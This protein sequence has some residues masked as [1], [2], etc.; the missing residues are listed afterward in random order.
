L[1]TAIY[2]FSG[3]GNSL[4]VA[5]ELQKRLPD[6][7]LIPMVSLL[8]QKVITINAETMGIVFPIHLSTAP[9]PVRLFTEKLDIKS[10]NFIFAIATRTGYKHRAFIEIDNLL[11]KKGRKL[12]AY[13]TLNFIDNN[14]RFESYKVPTPEL[15]AQ[16]ES[17]NLSKLD[18]IQQ[19]ILNRE[20]RRDKDTDFIYQNGALI[21]LLM[22]LFAFMAK[23]PGSNDDFYADSNCSGCGICEEVC[24]AHKIK[25]IADQ[26]VWE[27]SIK[28]YSCRACLNYCP[29]QSV[30]IK[31]TR[32]VKS[33]TDQ[34]GRYPH[35]FAT[36]ND[37]V[38][39]K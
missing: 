1:S 39:Q 26:P 33:Y 29:L 21:E 31:S 14:P 36:I 13:F 28:C 8:D 11:K 30:Q 24:L 22:P 18:A 6:S 23:H 37:I 12:D 27:E 10:A 7:T 4:F 20:S 15:I 25:M 32:L 35:P 9:L 38:G 3:T 5:R 17:E 34:N 19:L 16:I 2:Y